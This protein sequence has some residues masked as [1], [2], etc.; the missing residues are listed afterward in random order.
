MSIILRALSKIMGLTT[1]PVVERYYQ[2]NPEQSQR[3][4]R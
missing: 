3:S 2:S 4:L 1:G